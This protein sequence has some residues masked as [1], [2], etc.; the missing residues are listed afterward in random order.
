MKKF[1]KQAF[2]DIIESAKRQREI[3]RANFKAQKM[4]AK[5]FFQEQ[6]AMSNPQ[7]M[8][9]ILEKEYEEKLSQAKG[10]QETAQKRIDKAK[11]RG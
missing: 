10:R 6:K 7:V 4:E 8:K 9:K 1:F 5:A 2:R 3:D 11:G